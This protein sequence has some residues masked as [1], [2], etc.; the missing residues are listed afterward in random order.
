MKAEKD[1]III[2]AGPGGLTA[3][4]YGARANLSTAIFE[5]SSIGGQAVN[6]GE[7]ENYPG[8]PEALSGGE[9]CQKMKVQAER[10]GAEFHSSSVLSVKKH[11]DIF[12]VETESGTVTA[13]AVILATG[14]RHRMLDV[15]GEKE[16]IG[17]GVSYCASCDGFFFR[18]KKIIVVGGGDTAC[19]EALAL[20]KLSDK[21]I[22]IHRKDRF[23]AQ[24]ALAERVLS[25]RNIEVRFNTICTE[26]GGK[27][28]VEYAILEENRI[29][30]EQD[31]D[32]V[33][34]FTGIIPQNV[35][36]A[37]AA[38][39]AGG[40]VITDAYMNT[41][42]KGLFAI[43]DLRNSP[44][45]QVITACGDGAVAAHSAADYIDALKGEAYI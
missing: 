32:A 33:F 5:E 41:S 2:G 16:F 37:D 18:N 26:I 44:F 39:D 30:Y 27:N 45:R 23:R 24:K 22:M 21:I 34:I 15:P 40:Y 28:K 36:A 4:Q 42:V 19:S 6:I 25:N 14:S 35:L 29:K 9:L 17:R 3:A 7:L 43:G 20:A 13:Y 1:L 12:S 38:K 31:T 10:F 8:F 11:D